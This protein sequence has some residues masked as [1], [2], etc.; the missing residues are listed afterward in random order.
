MDA[1]ADLPEAIKA[2]MLAMVRAA[3]QLLSGGQ[4]PVDDDE[5]ERRIV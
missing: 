3:G 2:G 1:W 4:L 5:F